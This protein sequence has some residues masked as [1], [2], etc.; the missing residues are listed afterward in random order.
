MN[1]FVA[2]IVTVIDAYFFV[3][4]AS[5]VMSWL[6]AFDVV[7]MRNKF[8][9]MIAQALF[10]LTEPVYQPIRRFMPNLGGIDISPVVVILALQFLRNAII[11]YLG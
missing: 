7:N 1:P 5:V 9:A 6:V 4:I 11:Y 3:V 10:Q 8:A 2:L